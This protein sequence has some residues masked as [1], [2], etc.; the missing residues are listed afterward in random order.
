LL[1]ACWLLMLDYLKDICLSFLAL[2]LVYGF[3]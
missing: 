2:Y 1:I 3:M